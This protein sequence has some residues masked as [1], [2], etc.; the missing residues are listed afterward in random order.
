[1]KRDYPELEGKVVKCTDGIN[2][3][4]SRVVGCNYDIGI[5][6]VDADFQ[7]KYTFCLHGPSSPKWGEGRDK[8]KHSIEFPVWVEMIER[9]HVDTAYFYEKCGRKDFQNNPTKDNCPFGA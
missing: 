5:T 1:M 9:G 3:C 8:K 2:E 4:F 7:E 6:M